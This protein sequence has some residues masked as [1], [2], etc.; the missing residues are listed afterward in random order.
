VYN[1]WVVGLWTLYNQW[2]VGLW[3][4][5]TISGLWGCGL[6]VQSVG[7]RCSVSSQRQDYC[8]QYRGSEVV[9]SFCLRGSGVVDIIVPNQSS[10][11]KFA[12]VFK[13]H[14]F[15]QNMFFYPLVC[16]LYSFYTCNIA[17]QY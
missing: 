9:G 16:V 7:C 1:Q 2:V 11:L 15:A 17:F 6:C 12:V 3:T 8:L 14:Y 5:C 4:L 10:S 13:K